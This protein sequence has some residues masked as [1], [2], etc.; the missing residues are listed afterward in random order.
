VAATAKRA[1]LTLEPEPEPV[2][3]VEPLAARLGLTEREL[4]VLELVAAGTTN[5][6]IGERL[7]IS[8]KTASVHVSRILMK[9]DVTTRGEAAATAHRLRL[10]SD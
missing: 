3:E 8:T 10:V 6:Q 7:F 9:L 2:A 1:R 5:R 4:E